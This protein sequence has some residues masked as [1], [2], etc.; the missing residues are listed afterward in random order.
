MR[1]WLVPTSFR[2]DIVYAGGC[3]FLCALTRCNNPNSVRAR[4]YLASR[5]NCVYADNDADDHD[6]CSEPPGVCFDRDI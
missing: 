6:L 5:G 3:K 1:G 2:P 4:L